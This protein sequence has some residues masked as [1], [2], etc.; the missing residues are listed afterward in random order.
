MSASDWA[1]GF[2]SLGGMALTS[3][4]TGK[5]IAATDHCAAVV[6]RCPDCLDVFIQS[7]TSTHEC[8]QQRLRSLAIIESNSPTEAM[9]A[10]CERLR[11]KWE[12][13][14]QPLLALNDDPEVAA[15]RVSFDKAVGLANAK[16]SA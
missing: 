9:A 1:R 13:A 4:W 3:R 5:R 8:R 14:D 2:D 16:A 11:A 10:A 6:K 15:L 7:R 12:D